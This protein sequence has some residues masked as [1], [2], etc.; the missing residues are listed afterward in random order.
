MVIDCNVCGKPLTT[1]VNKEYVKL[2]CPACGQSIVV[3]GARFTQAILPKMFPSSDINKWPASMIVD[4]AK[5]WQTTYMLQLKA[6]L[7]ANWISQAQ[8]DKTK[9][10]LDIEVE[11]FLESHKKEKIMSKRYTSWYEFLKAFLPRTYKKLTRK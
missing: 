4:Y 3:T 8:Y 10:D 1:D 5:D 11:K 9:A 2:S 7:L 6:N